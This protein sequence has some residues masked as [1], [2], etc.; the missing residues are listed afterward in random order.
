[1]KKRIT[2]YADEGKVLTNGK[3]YG[4]EITLEIGRSDDEWHEITAEEY[5]VIVA[6][7]EAEAAKPV[8]FW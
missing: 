5:A 1:M 4:T 7:Q 2:M 6:E 3:E 8:F